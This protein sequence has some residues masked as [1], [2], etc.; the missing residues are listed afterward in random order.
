MKNKIS[1]CWRW[2]IY[3]WSIY[4]K[5]L[6]AVYCFLIAYDG[7]LIAAVLIADDELPIYKRDVKQ[8][9][10]I[11]TLEHSAKH[12]CAIQVNHPTLKPR[13]KLYC[14]CFK[15]Y[16]ILLLNLSYA[17]E[18]HSTHMHNLSVNNVWCFFYSLLLKSRVSPQ[19][20]LRH[21]Q[22]SVL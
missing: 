5:H 18:Y 17:V 19:A 7:L 10:G 9:H 20:W 14:Y 11:K 13:D 22:C 15:W 6:Q 3:M 16:L 8:I 12:L 21:S 1:G 2:P 4:S